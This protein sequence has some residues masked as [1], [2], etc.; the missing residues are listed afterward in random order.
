MKQPSNNQKGLSLVECIVALGLTTVAIVSL[1]SMQS[2]AWR[3]AGKSDYLGR[4]IGI[5]QREL[6]QN[7]LAIMKG[8]IPANTQTCA[9]KDGSAVACNSAEKMFTLN[10]TTTPCFCSGTTAC[11]CP[12]TAAAT[13][14]T[15]RFNVRITWPGSEK[16]MSSSVIVSRQAA[17]D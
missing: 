12:N 15:W 17:F 13:A 6:E 3:G 9:D 10:K 2:M 8:A 4:A 1:I 16:G 5:I 11:V 7:Q 14:N